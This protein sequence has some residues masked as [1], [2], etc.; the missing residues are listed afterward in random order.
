[1]GA[2]AVKLKSHAN[3]N[4]LL[5]AGWGG[6]LWPLSAEIIR[7]TYPGWAAADI[8]AFSAMLRDAYL[9][10]TIKGSGANGNWELVVIEAS[11]RIAVFLDEQGQL[12]PRGGDGA[13]AGAGVH[14]PEDRRGHPRATALGGSKVLVAFARAER[15]FVD[16]LA[17]ETCRD[18]L[19][20]QYGI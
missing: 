18:F 5:Q 4:A 2:W 7:H 12:R 1:M 17:Q 8:A 11:I 10:T 19:H 15:C 13:Q 16:G 6:A 9:A 14:V 3:G 20:T